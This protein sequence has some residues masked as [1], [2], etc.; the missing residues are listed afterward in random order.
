MAFCA[1]YF[2]FTSHTVGN[3]RTATD[4]LAHRSGITSS[5]V[6]TPL[7]AIAAETI[8]E[9]GGAANAFA[10]LEKIERFEALGTF[11]GGFALATPWQ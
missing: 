4:T 1:S 7:I 5:A 11:G 10:I 2:T 6:V 3:E 9:L 8:F